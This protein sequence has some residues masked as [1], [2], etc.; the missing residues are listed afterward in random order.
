MATQLPPERTSSYL[1]Y[2]PAVFQQVGEGQSAFFIGRLLL[3]FERV[4]SG[5]GDPAQPG[6]EETIDRIHTYFDP[7]PT[8]PGRPVIEKERAPAEFL[9]WLA[10]WVAL[11]LREDWEEEEKRRFISRIAPLYRLRGTKVGLAEMLRTYTGM[12]VDIREFHEPLQIGVTFALGVDT[13]IGGAPAHYFFVHMIL[14][15]PDPTSFARKE[16]IARAIIDQE[17]PAH[18]YYD[19]QI[20][21][22]TIQIG[23]RSTVGVNTILGTP[24]N[25]I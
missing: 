8:Q 16:Q 1:N 4:L 2:L 24:H 12:E 19:L 25:D 17:K 14:E 5:L 10:S 15:N 11:S 3:A 6:L 9:P 21:T 13:L 20:Q 7:G 22:P 18:T 23:I